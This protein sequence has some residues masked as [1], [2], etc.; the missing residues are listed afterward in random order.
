MFWHAFLA[1][2]LQCLMPRRPR[3]MLANVPLHIISRGNNRHA[4]FFADDDDH[5]YLAWLQNDAIATE[6]RVHAYVLMTNPVH[7]LLSC[8][9]RDGVGALM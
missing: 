8:S 2:G 5:F 1:G 4:R 7:M 3:L 9:V 6:C